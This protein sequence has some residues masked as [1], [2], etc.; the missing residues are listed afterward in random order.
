MYTFVDKDGQPNQTI[1]K[2]LSKLED[3]F[4]RL[5]RDKIMRSEPLTDQDKATLCLFVATA[6]FRTQRSQNH[7]REQWG[8]V[9][10]MGERMTEHMQSLSAEERAAMQTPLPGT[11]PTFNQDEIRLLADSVRMLPMVTTREAELLSYMTVTIFCTSDDSPFITSDSPVVWFDPELYKMPP[12]YRN[13]ALG[14][15]T[16][17]VT[18]PIAPSKFLLMR[19]GGDQEQYLNISPTEN[20]GANISL[21]PSHLVDV[22]N[23]L[24]TI[25]AELVDEF[26]RRTRFHCDEHFVSSSDQKK[27]H[28]V[29]PRHASSRLARSLLIL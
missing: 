8:R 14:S 27:G 6:H 24:S 23:R 2:G 19:H 3:Q 20:V 9:A 10:V 13:L 26:N 12:F 4:E 15:P 17:E 11:G 18:M 29:R 5:R 22:L 1:E 21:L 28:L 7:W 25:G 16:I